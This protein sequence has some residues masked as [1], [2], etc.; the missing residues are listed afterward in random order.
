MPEQSALLLDLIQ[1]MQVVHRGKGEG[2]RAALLQ[3]DTMVYMASMF[4][5]GRVLFEIHIAA[6]TR[7]IC[8]SKFALIFVKWLFSRG[9]AHTDYR[10]KSAKAV[11][12]GREHRMTGQMH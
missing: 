4:G 2:E 6:S 9:N 8:P 11:F 5:R 12:A 3:L 1:L 10:S 7:P